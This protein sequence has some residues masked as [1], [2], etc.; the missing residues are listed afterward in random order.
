MHSL[1]ELEVLQDVAS[2]LDRA[3]FAYMLTGS[4]AMNYYAQPR[5]T[6]DID[7]VVALSSN[8]IPQIMRSFQQ[9]YYVSDEAVSNAI[10]DTT[11]FNLV[12]LESVVKIDIIVRKPGRYRRLEFDRRVP[13]KIS[14]IKTWMVSKEDLIL[15][16]LY[17]ARDTQSEMQI[18]DVKNLLLM[19]PDLV[20]LKKWAPGL[21]VNE[22]LEE[23]LNE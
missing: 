13:V 7:I 19:S 20:Y 16:K 17:W 2:R 11:M 8:D 23:C 15:S 9:N 21:G 4:M 12:H 5:M 18:S 22:L 6:R 3:G 14:G 10:K 1:S